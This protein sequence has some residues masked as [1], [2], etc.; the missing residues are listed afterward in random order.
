MINVAASGTMKSSAVTV[1][2][3]PVL[4]VRDNVAI[5]PLGLPVLKKKGAVPAV[6]LSE[7]VALNGPCWVISVPIRDQS[8]A[9]ALGPSLRVQLCRSIAGFANG[10]PEERS[11]WGPKATGNSP[12]CQNRPRDG[13]IRDPPVRAR[14]QNLCPRHRAPYLPLRS[15]PQLSL[16]RGA[17]LEIHPG[18]MSNKPINKATPDEVAHWSLR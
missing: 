10:V 15:Q 1:S 16:G 8:G 3:L 17:G 18:F 5:N 12:H 4:A 7:K 9:S 14:E 2:S 13:R 6:P 11:A